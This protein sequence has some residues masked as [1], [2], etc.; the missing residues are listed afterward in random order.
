MKYGQ[1]QGTIEEDP[2][3]DVSRFRPVTKTSS[4]CSIAL[5]VFTRRV[6]LAMAGLSIFING[7]L[8]MLTVSSLALLCCQFLS[9]L[10]VV[11]RITDFRFSTITELISVYESSTEDWQDGSR[12]T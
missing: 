3:S 8:M 5:S 2:R 4:V 11:L 10:F 1:R 9:N 12:R 7:N 6:G